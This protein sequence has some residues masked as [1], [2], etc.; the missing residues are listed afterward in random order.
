[1]FSVAKGFA[2]LKRAIP[3]EMFLHCASLWSC[4][5]NW[6][7]IMTPKTF[8]LDTWFIIWFPMTIC[9]TLGMS[10]IFCRDPTIINSVFSV[11]NVN[12]L[13]NN[14]LCTFS[15]SVFSLCSMSL[16]ELLQ[17]DNY[18]GVVREHILFVDLNLAKLHFSP[19]G[20]GINYNCYAQFP[21]TIYCV[22]WFGRNFLCISLSFKN[23]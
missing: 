8:L 15:R 5:F 20:R 17:H 11:F 13:A 9:G 4:H 19:E 18:V 21:T 2:L 3:F 16:G 14:H 1:M 22:L 23:I 7:L 6:S 12:L 10:F